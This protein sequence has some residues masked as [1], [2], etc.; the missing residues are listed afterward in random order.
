MDLSIVIPA[1][2]E[3]KNLEV[4]LPELNR[5]LSASG[6]NGEI[7]VVD[8]MQP[9]DDAPAVCKRFNARY[10]NRAGGNNYGDAVR[11]GIANADG[12]YVI[13]MDADGSHSPSFIPKL[14][15]ERDNYDIVIASRYVESGGSDNAL[16]LIAMSKTLNITYSLILNIPCNDVSNSFKLYHGEQL[17]KLELFCDNFDIVEEIIFKLC[18]NGKNVR[19]KEL[20][21]FFKARLFGKTKRNLVLFICTYLIT[22]LRLRFRK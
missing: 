1:Y 14:L 15:A 4:L 12:K 10:I 21:F 13:F 19:I 9:M 20:P 5:V 3:D 16:L 17:K 18:R 7:L 6:L 8:T 11:T 2:K 22:I